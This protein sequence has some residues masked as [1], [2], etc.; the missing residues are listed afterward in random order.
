MKR[1]LKE[2][3]LSMCDF[4]FFQ[5][6]KKDCIFT[7]IITKILITILWFSGEMYYVHS[8]ECYYK[9]IKNY[10]DFNR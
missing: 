7:C 4:A 1:E 9:Y 3:V 10:V 2:Y 8:K 5:T 6:R